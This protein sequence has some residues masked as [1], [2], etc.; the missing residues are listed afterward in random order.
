MSW[1]SQN[2]HNIGVQ[3]NNIGCDFHFADLLTVYPNNQLKVFII[4]HLPIATHKNFII[5]ISDNTNIATEMGFCF[6]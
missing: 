6:Q 5:T 3:Y 4:E 2:S 1:L